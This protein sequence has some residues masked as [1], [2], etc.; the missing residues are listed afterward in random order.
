VLTR[1]RLNLQRGL[2][3]YGIPGNSF[4]QIGFATECAASDAD[5][6]L[7]TAR[8]ARSRSRKWPGSPKLHWLTTRS[9]V[10][11]RCPGSQYCCA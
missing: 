4:H 10:Y 2:S 1:V 6:L 11:W 7:R 3:R 8:R 9:Q 5:T